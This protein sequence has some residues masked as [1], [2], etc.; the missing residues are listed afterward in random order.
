MLTVQQ[1]LGMVL[2]LLGKYEQ[3]KELLHDV[4][5]ALGERGAEPVSLRAGRAWKMPAKCDASA[6]WVAPMSAPL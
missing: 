3:A 4:A 6:A 5:P 1:R 2:A